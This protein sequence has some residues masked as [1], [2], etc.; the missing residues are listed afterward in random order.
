MTVN[1]WRRVIAKAIEEICDPKKLPKYDRDV[2]RR[3]AIKKFPHANETLLAGIVKHG[4]EYW[5]MERRKLA[6]G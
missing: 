1:E 4:K 6:G 2:V 3:A 5:D